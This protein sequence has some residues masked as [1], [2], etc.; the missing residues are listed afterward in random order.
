MFNIGLIGYGNMGSMI[1]NN[2]LKLDL[3]LEDE[4]L[5]VSNHN[6]SK[7]ESLKEIYPDVTITDDNKVIAENCDVIII[8]VKSPDFKD[9]ICEIKPYLKNNVHIITSCAG[10]NFKEVE[11]YYE[12][13]LSIVIPTLASYVGQASEITSNNRRKGITLFT[14]NSNVSNPER[15]FIEGLF[16]EFSFVKVVHDYED[17]KIATI[18]TSCSPALLSLLVEKIADIADKNS[19]FSKDDVVYLITKSLLGTGLILDDSFETNE[20][21]EKVATPGGITQFG[22]DYLDSEISEDSKELF[23]IL[24]KK[25]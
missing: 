20:V 24:L 14:H 15:V 1:V 17:L 22:L 23:K 6:M 16:D 10:I 3:L 7:I 2:I 18:L 4:V 13:S 12:G 8:C 19:N 21:I 11:D 5:F 25:Y 9:V